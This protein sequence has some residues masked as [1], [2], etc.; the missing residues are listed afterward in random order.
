MK[1]LMRL[2]LRLAS[3][4]VKA[5]WYGWQPFAVAAVEQ[6]RRKKNIYPWFSEEELQTRSQ[7]LHVAVQAESERLTQE[8]KRA[9]EKR[10]LLTLIENPN[11]SQTAFDTKSPQTRT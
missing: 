5:L 1:A 8:Y 3:P 6:R 2:G 4:E 9:V 7:R 10:R 11:R